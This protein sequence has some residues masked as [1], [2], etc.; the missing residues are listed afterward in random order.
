MS[1]PKK[2]ELIQ[3]LE[4]GE[5]RASLMEEFGVSSSTMYDIRKQKEKLLSFVGSTECPTKKIEKR[6][7]LKGS[8]I[9]ELD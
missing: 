4:K 1:I 9:P 3:R 6:K 8:T 7:S 5:S 2:V